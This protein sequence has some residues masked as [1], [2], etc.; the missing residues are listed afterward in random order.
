[1]SLSLFGRTGLR[2]LFLLL[3][4]FGCTSLLGCPGY[5]CTAALI[6]SIRVV[7]VVALAA[8]IGSGAIIIG[9]N[10]YST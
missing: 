4:G 9:F 7:V 10:V 5:G 3:V 1:M 8:C 6:T 2:L